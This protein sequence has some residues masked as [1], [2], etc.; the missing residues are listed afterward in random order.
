MTTGISSS[1][2]TTS[3]LPVI[4]PPANPFRNNLSS[5]QFYS[6]SPSPN[7]SNQI[8]PSSPSSTPSHSSKNSFVFGFIYQPL[9]STPSSSDPS[10]LP[11]FRILLADNET[12]ILTS[13]YAT[14]NGL[15]LRTQFASIST[16]LKNTIKT[17]Q[18]LAKS[19]ISNFT[20]TMVTE[21]TEAKKALLGEKFTCLKSLSAEET[22]SIERAAPFHMAIIDGNLQRSH[23][24][25]MVMKEVMTSHNP[26]VEKTLILPHSSDLDVSNPQEQRKPLLDQL[27]AVGIQPLHIL[28]KN[29]TP[30]TQNEFLENVSKA[31]LVQLGSQFTAQETP[32]APEKTPSPISPK[33]PGST[34]TRHHKLPL[35]RT[36]SL[37][38]PLQISNISSSEL[39]PLLPPLS[40]TLNPSGSTSE[41]PPLSVSFAPFSA[42]A[43]SSPSQSL[44]QQPS[45]TKPPPN[46]TL[47]P[48]FSLTTLEPYSLSLATS[49]SNPTLSSSPGSQFKPPLA[50]VPPLPSLPIFEPTTKATP[51]SEKMETTT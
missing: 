12:T 4:C 37:T 40:F 31:V 18:D 22:I 15:L 21:A 20:I 9:S 14:L 26:F 33:T 45:A 29:G 51:T 50:S 25:F 27:F 24:G 35:S 8:V 28:P 38:S 3:S 5:L 10:T 19:R 47:N 6:P 48:S 13:L 1:T 44:T 36:A 16:S 30:E 17:I 41:L 39:P 23:D 49:L 34:H 42:Q 11:E 43:S 32:S 2:T 7:P 46:F